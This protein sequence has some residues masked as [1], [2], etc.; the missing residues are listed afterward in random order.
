MATRARGV[1]ILLAIVG[2]IA[3]IIVE[4]EPRWHHY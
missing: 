1:L 4:T 3:W 2:V